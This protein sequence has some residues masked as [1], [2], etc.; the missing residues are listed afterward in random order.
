M[1]LTPVMGRPTDQ[2]RVAEI[3]KRGVLCLLSD[4]LRAERPGFTPSEK[5][6]GEVFER[7]ITDCKGRF[8]VTTMSSNISRFKQAIEVS[9]KHGRKIV[10]V[11]RSVEKNI[12]MAL[13]LGYLNFPKDVFLGIKQIDQVP[14]SKITLLV[15]GSQAQ[16][17]SA[18]ERI[19]SGDHE[20]KIA[21]DDKI[22]FSTDYIPGNELAINELIDNILRAGAEVS[23]VNINSDIHVSGHGA[24]SDLKK[25][26]ELVKPKYFLPIGGNYRHMIAYQ[27]LAVGLGYKKENVLLPDG[28]QMIELDDSKTAKILPEVRLGTVIIDALGVGDVGNVVLRD[29]QVLSQEGMVVAVIL[30]NRSTGE[31]INDPEIISRGFVYVKDSEELLNQARRQIRLI[32]KNAQ[33]RRVGLRILREDIQASLEKMF[34]TKTGRRPMVLSQIIEV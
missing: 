22:V 32:L 7:E 17:G 10:L 8:L 5:N 1:D 3:G 12:E 34:L 16:A 6:L 9:V 19:V 26:I 27:K 18:L 11:G 24:A 2:K 28:N 14:P 25:L 23:Y 30:L 4:C 15:A 31:I 13:K 20:I 21:P 33:N 29:R